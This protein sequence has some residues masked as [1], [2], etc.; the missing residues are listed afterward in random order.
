M[1]AVSVRSQKFIESQLTARKVESIGLLPKETRR[2]IKKEARKIAL[3]DV[4]GHDHQT[5]KKTGNPIEQGLGADGNMTAQSI[6]AY[7]KNQTERRKGGP[8]PGFEDTL[9]DM[10]VKLAKC[11]ARR[12]AEAAAADDDDD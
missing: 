5:D 11:D 12:R 10:R 4:F 2:D 9:K 1:D 7:I 3:A 6:E 8:E